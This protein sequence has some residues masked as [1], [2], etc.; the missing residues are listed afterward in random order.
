MGETFPV[1]AIVGRPNVGKST[2]FN[3]LIRQRKAIVGDR[4]GVTVDRLESEWRLGDRMV[5]LV[6]TGG[7]GQDDHDDM[8]SGIERQ[9][10]AALDVAD[11]VV[12]VVDGEAGL[13]PADQSIA[14]K[15]RRQ[16]M[17]VVLVV[18]KAENP[19]IV[20]EFFSLGMGDPVAV[21]ALHGHGVRQLKDILGQHLPVRCVSRKSKSNILASLA[22]VGRPNVGK[23][24]LINAWLGR[25]RMVVSSRAG[26]TRDA[27]DAD[28]P[29]VDKE[30]KGIVRLVDTAGQRRHARIRD[31]IEFVARVK[32]QQAFARADAAM[33]L[34][35]GS[36]DVAEQDMRL[37]ALAQ[38]K[39]CALL[40]AVN[41]VDLMDDEA[42]KCY[43]E[44]LDFRMR[45]LADIPVFRIAA[46]QGKG[47]KGLL[48]HAVEAARRNRRMLNTGEL[49]RWLATAQEKQQP[50]SDDGAAVRMKYC[51]QVATSPPAIKIFCNRPG[52][53][54]QTY[55]RYLAHDFRKRFDLPG[56]PVR[57]I[58]L[59]TKNPYAPQDSGSG[60]N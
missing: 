60:K 4:P 49:N 32:A 42:W 35:D 6:D 15:L 40:V 41:K 55:R 59:V 21:S 43:A 39:G 54:R 30:G 58:F 45:G 52:A 47:V 3:S 13:V 29:Y 51:T 8:Q 5:T 44:R 26:T 1:I 10:E 34:L 7:M 33:L 48:K 9:V 57:L 19:D 18:N 24:T 23:S 56:I 11:V 36:E 12:F 31:A 17:D 46:K 38:E 16:N 2:L 20:V 28:M 53:M 50:P 37:M 14:D 27:V 22:V 25:E